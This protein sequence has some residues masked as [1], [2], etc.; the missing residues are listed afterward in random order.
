[1]PHLMADWLLARAAE[2][3]P[4]RSVGSAPL[5]GSPAVPWQRA[6]DDATHYVSFAEWMCP[7]NCI[8]PPRCPHTRG[9][10]SWTMPAAVRAYVEAELAA[11][12][13]VEGPY[14]FQCLHR[15]YGVGMLDVGD[16]VAA[17]RAVAARG[18]L[19]AASFLVGTVSHCH[20]ALRQI[21]LG[22]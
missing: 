16:I 3:W 21:V 15:A 20:G 6:G 14:V 12:R 8:E 2:R 22:A 17:D 10:R 1:M 18:A 9:E 7:I 19:G 4:G 5:G 11:G 13:P